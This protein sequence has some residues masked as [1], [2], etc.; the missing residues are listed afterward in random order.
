MNKFDF[1][2]VVIGSGPGGYIAALRAAELGLSVACIE[3]MDTAGG[4][5]LNVG[6]IPSKALLHT[7]AAYDWI[8]KS[9]GDEGIHVKDLSYDLPT[10]MKRKDS[11]VKGLVD[12]IALLFKSKGVVSLKG[13]ASFV[14][15]HT[16]VVQ[17]KKVTAENIIIA[18]G[19]EPI[20]LPF[21]VF[22][23]KQVVSSTGALSLTV[24]P[25]KLVVIGAGAIGVELASVYSRLGSSVTVVEM[26][27]TITPAMDAAICKHLQQAL[28]KQ[29]IEF[30]LQAKVKAGTVSSTGV[31]LAI[32]HESRQISLAADVVLVA[33][34][35]RPYT[36]G[37]HLETA[38]ISTT[39]KGFIPVDNNF[40]TEQKHIYAIGDVIDGPMLAH[41]ASHEG[42]AVA[43]L[44]AGKASRINYTSIPNVIY[45]HPEAASVGFT[46]AEARAAG[47][48]IAVSQSYFRA[49][50]R[51][52]STGET[53]G[54]VKIVGDIP[55][56][57]LIGMH[58]LGADASEMIAEGVV[59]IDMK[60]TIDDV[61]NACH[62]HPT[63]SEA[64]MEACQNFLD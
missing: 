3:K 5:C 22:D 39:L 21:L 50:G 33:V 32:E 18:T 9:S 4:T 63:L 23:E 29:G 41:K 54:F 11:V 19:S 53:E 51:A 57:R 34:G 55:T 52:R 30:L 42:V 6:C 38:G 10:M 44:I 31:T 35:R 47:L 12:G 59:A 13:S 7:S 8:K 17:G 37:L 24:V 56:R 20:A 49:N 60:A 64:I 26:L 61:A 16:L 43:N 27:E 1:K 14:D 58:I 2:V 40:Q 45:T 46:E 48:N 25:E 62:P 28:Q 15:P 36:H